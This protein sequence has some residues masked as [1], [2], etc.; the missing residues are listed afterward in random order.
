MNLGTDCRT[1]HETTQAYVHSY[2]PAADYVGGHVAPVVHA[3]R[4]GEGIAV[5]R[6]YIRVAAIQ[7]LAEG[8]GPQERG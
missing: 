1:G 8:D 7:P 5:P 4:K 3:I 6:G 2:V